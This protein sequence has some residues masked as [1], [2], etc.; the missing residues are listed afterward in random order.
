MIVVLTLIGAASGLTL[1]LIHRV[2]AAPIEYQ[3]IK[4]VKEPAVKKV[5]TGYD[6][7]PI[8]DRKKI[9]MGTDLRGRPVELTVF[10]A[11]KA[12]ETFA[13]A[14]EGSGKGFH[15]Q[16]GVMVG[17]SKE[18]KILD[19]GITSLSETPGIGS[20]V[21]APSYTD[22]YKGLAATKDIQVDAISGATYS[23]K[24]VVAAVNEAVGY[25][26][27]FRKEIF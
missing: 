14:V 9:P 3:T 25:V 10:P 19:I 8:L 26:L 23:S 24:G 1:S 4:F 22:Q 15:G 27:K 12:G 16:I 5:L 18:G 13:V 2:T 11:R 17:V 20:R 21:T 7:D 6:N